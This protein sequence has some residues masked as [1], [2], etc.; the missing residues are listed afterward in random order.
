[1]SRGLGRLQVALLSIIR[2]HAKPMT[3][4]AIQADIKQQIG[5]GPEARLRPSFE[6]SLRRALHGLVDHWHL[7]T[8]G[9]G[10]PGDPLR[11]FI[12]PL[13]IG[14]MGDTPESQRLREAIEADPGAEAASDR[15][16]RKAFNRSPA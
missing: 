9:D 16:M 10:G 14:T 1:M 2:R 11:Y 7:I 3:F 13:A 4:A 5:A 6:R 12:H 15:W 8:M